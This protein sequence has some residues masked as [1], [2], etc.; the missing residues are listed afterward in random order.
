[1]PKTNFSLQSSNANL[2]KIAFEVQN[3]YAQG[4]PEFPKLSFNLEVK[5]SPWADISKATQTVHPVTWLSLSGF[6]RRAVTRMV[7]FLLSRK[8]MLISIQHRRNARHC[9]H[10]AFT[11]AVHKGPAQH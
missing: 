4:G 5:L 2:G 1:M 7:Q 6:V 10:H 9:L 8:K 11:R 3:V